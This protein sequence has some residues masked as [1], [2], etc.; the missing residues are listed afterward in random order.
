MEALL[1]ACG[2]LWLAAV[3]AGS[4]NAAAA[5]KALEIGRASWRERVLIQV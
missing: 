5:W 4:E 3:T 1:L 2:T